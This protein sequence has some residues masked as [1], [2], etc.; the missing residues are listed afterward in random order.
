MKLL[1]F[2][3]LL[4][5]TLGNDDILEGLGNEN[6]PQFQNLNEETS[7]VDSIQGANSVEDARN[8]EI[9]EREEEEK[10]IDAAF[11]SA[12]ADQKVH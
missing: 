3:P 7:V 12:Q 4:G 1:T 11:E 5:V 2:L 9:K 6:S 10:A 8:K